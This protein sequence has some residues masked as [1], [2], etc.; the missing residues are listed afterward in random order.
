MMVL[1]RQMIQSKSMNMKKLPF[2]AICFA[3]LSQIPQIAHCTEAMQHKITEVS[4]KIIERTDIDGSD[5]ELRL[6]LVEFPPG[7]ASPAHLH[8][9]V[10]LNYI[11]EGAAESQY[12]GEPLKTLHA[13]DSYQDLANRKHLVFRNASKTAG[14]KFIVAYTIA[15]DLPFMQPLSENTKSTGQ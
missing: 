6:M 2:M 13:G 14:L 8:P 4:R 3:A 12:E 7:Y 5:E 9:V 15:K 1:I 11:V 10:G